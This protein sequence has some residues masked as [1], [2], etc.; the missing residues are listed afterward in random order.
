[1]AMTRR[2]PTSNETAI[3]YNEVDGL[4]P[5]CDGAIMYEKSGRKLKNFDAAHLYPLNPTK[6]EE[7]L[8]ANEERL[9]SH[10]NALENFILLCKNC[11]TQF[12]NPRTVA[13]Y[14]K[15]LH[16]KK[17]AIRRDEA[18]KTWHDYR[19]ETELRSVIQSLSSYDSIPDEATLSY[20]SK[21]V[22]SKTKNIPSA[23]KKRMIRRHVSDYFIYIRQ[24]FKNLES[25]SPGKAQQ[26]A[27]QV[28]AFYLSQAPASKDA[29]ERYDGVVN[30]IERRVSGCSPDSAQVLA[31]FFV[32]N[33]EV[34]E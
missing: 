20:D 6:Q 1:M 19:L 27:S 12:D 5:Q 26:I 14:R 30:W 11:H 7:A 3:L 23:I 17:K 18:R 28:R 24:L 10:V 9:T 29:A 16:L 33:C 25:S 15:L 2:T 22:E 4:C 31:A 13:D 32:Q 8:L 21:T 34:L